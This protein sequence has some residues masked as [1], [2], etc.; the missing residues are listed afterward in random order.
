MT[1]GG[2]LGSQTKGVGFKDIQ[3]GHGGPFLRHTC[4]DGVPQSQGGSGHN[5]DLVL[6]TVHGGV[7][8]I[9]EP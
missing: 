3:H 7:L 1:G 2:Q 9:F 8:R 6:E 4:G 5:G